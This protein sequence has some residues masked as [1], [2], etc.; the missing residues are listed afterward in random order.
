MRIH[1]NERIRV[2][3]PDLKVLATIIEG[4][5]VK[6]EDPN[7]ELLKNEVIKE[8]KSKYRIES[9]KDAPSFKAYREF[10]WRIGIDPTKSRPA[11]EA[12]MRRVLL[13]NPL[14]KINTFVDS[15]NLASLKSEVAIGSFDL[16]K[17]SGE[18]VVIRYADRGE[19]FHGIG[20]SQPIV[21]KGREIVISDDMGVIAIYPH[22]DSERTKITEATRRILL[23][24]CRVP[25]IDAS[26]LLEAMNFTTS[27]ITRFCGGSIKSIEVE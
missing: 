21:L 19:V 2:D 3:F 26:M 9:L 22:R 25:G 20:M 5:K 17:V 15:L 8:A 14:P 16:D 23:V 27:L 7:L 10:F 24:F 18:L 6:N 1:I 13:D 11:A 4:L 12:L